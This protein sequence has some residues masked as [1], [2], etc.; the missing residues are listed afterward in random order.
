[1]NFTIPQLTP[2]STPAAD[3]YFEL[4]GALSGSN[5]ILASVFVLSTQSLIAG[6]SINLSGSWPSQTVALSNTPSI[7]S[8]TGT[9]TVLTRN[10]GQYH[11]SL[12]RS[13]AFAR[14]YGLG[15]NSGTGE[16][17][18]DDL[19][20]NA[21][22]FRITPT[23]TA[24]I[25]GGLE[26][27]PVGAVTP[28]V[29]TFTNLSATGTTLTRND[30][31]YHLS[32][33]RSSVFARSYGLA[34][35]S[36]TGEFI[37]DDITANATRL[38][39]S[40]AGALT[41]AGGIVAALTG[42]ATTATTLAVARTI[43]GI[44]F[45]GSANIT[46]P[47][48]PVG[49]PDR[50]HLRALTGMVDNQYAVEAGYYFFTDGGGG[51]WIFN[52]GDTSSTDNDG[53]LI[54]PGGTYGTVATAGC[55]HRAGTAAYGH[56]VNDLNSTLLDVR[57]FGAI[58]NESDCVPGVTKAF[59]YLNSQPGVKQ[60]G[61]LIFPGGTY[62]I[63]SKLV[64]DC[65]GLGGV[66][67]TIKGDGPGATTLTYGM[68]AADTCLIEIKNATLGS[69]ENLS[70]QS[71]PYGGI[72]YSPSVLWV[73]DTT[74]FS[75]RNIQGLNLVSTARNN[76]DGG[77]FQVGPNNDLLVVDGC[78]SIGS[79]SIGTA[80]HYAGGSGIISNSSFKTSGPTPC[81][82]VSVSNTMMMYQNFFQGGGPY[83]SFV[84]AI[85]TSTVSNFT[86]TSTAHGF[87]SGDY[88]VLR[89]ASHAGYN[90]RW[91]ISSVTANTLVILSAA[92]LGSDTAT[93]ESLSSC[94]Y[95]SPRGSNVI[96]E[97]QMS[98][99]FF[100]TGGSPGVGS[101]GI[102]LDQ[103][104]L[105]SIG[106]LSISNCLTDYGFTSIF[107]HGTV[108]TDGQFASNLGGLSITN[109]R[110]NTG[111]ADDFGGIRLEGVVDCTVTG[112]RGFPGNNVTPG[113]G[114]TFNSIV[115]SDGG[116]AHRTG[117]ITINGGS[118]TNRNSSNLYSA[119]TI[120]ALVFDG[121][122]VYD[123]TVTN[124]GL[125]TES[126]NAYAFKFI[127]G[128]VATNG[129]SVVY[130][131][132]QGLITNLNTSVLNS[133]SIITPLI[134]VAEVA[135][136]DIT[137]STATIGISSIQVLKSVVE[138]GYAVVGANTL[139]FG[140]TNNAYIAATGN[141]TFTTVN[142]SSGNQF[143]L[144]IVNT[145]GGAISLSFPAWKWSN[146]AAPTTLAAGLGIVIEAWAYG[147]TNS[148]VFA[149]Y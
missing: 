84:G 54:V 102:F 75:V 116:A 68:T 33:V 7:G 37:L 120:N 85:I 140:S 9:S 130:S 61:G 27:T 117:A 4:G 143:R 13:S 115:I 100:N 21:T 71:P 15:I 122:Q 129:I 103:W 23:G 96:T 64:F 89:G 41:V 70:I 50:A 19:T 43:N 114:K 20:A 101:V 126:S 142:L 99:C 138:F 77:H 127:N 42:N 74:S 79:S 73:H 107:A 11:L 46:L 48:G 67:I 62:R 34:I 133:T 2:V 56:G 149:K 144:A 98:D 60:Y 97:G 8:A 39:V 49:I 95:I 123:V 28:N 24:T 136:V 25:A 55:W 40:P 17:I 44:P 82:H 16:L 81:L 18:L 135:S 5:K 109:Q 134:T 51:T 110:Q 121:P 6:N 12:I 72:I 124:P 31:Q 132:H 35:N 83:K 69:F 45:D 145:T 87:L 38:R 119:A 59:A 141:L 66:G 94:A 118:L 106:Q 125:D 139:D 104:Y 90:T 108:V 80:F 29:G 93:L 14:S 30:G 57:W 147:L 10:D 131:N 146:V 137:T 63:S 58:A 36:G 88:I 22:R 1:M 111:A 105:G 112:Y 76:A 65:S 92:N 113:T 78:L 26:N 53:T 128:A 3:H 52:I 148:T 91:K 47:S 86:I 32:L